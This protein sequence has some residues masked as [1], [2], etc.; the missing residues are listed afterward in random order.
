MPEAALLDDREEGVRVEQAAS[1]VLPADER[2][3]TEGGARC[4]VELRLVVQHELMVAQGR[5]Q[6]L[7][8]LEPDAVDLVEPRVVAGGPRARVLGGIHRDVGAPQ[9]VDDAEPALVALG[10][11]VARVDEQPARSMTKGAVIRSRMRIAILRLSAAGARVIRSA[12]SSPRRRTRRLRPP[13]RR[14]P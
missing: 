6:I 11:A 2:L 8:R 12:N 9:Q 7:D 10:D 4:H 1:G 3:R 13:A 14:R 5:V